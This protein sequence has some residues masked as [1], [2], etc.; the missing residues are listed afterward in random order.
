MRNYASLAS[1]QETDN[2][3]RVFDTFQPAKQCFDLTVVQQKLSES[4]DVFRVLLK[5][6][7]IKSPAAKA[8]EFH[9]EDIAQLM[10]LEWNA[11]PLSQKDFTHSRPIVS[12]K[13]LNNIF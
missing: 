6:K 11:T 4:K 7:P 5:G 12:I 9:N 10:A 3:P 13:L 8:L 2:A 1:T